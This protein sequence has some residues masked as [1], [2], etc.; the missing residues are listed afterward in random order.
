[1]EDTLLPLESESLDAKISLEPSGC[2][3]CISRLQQSTQQPSCGSP[4]A[5]FSLVLSDLYEFSDVATKAHHSSSSGT[6]ISQ[7]RA[8]RPDPTRTRA[9]ARDAHYI[10]LNQ[11]NRC[12]VRPAVRDVPGKTSKHGRSAPT[13]DLHYGNPP[14]AF[15]RRCR[16]GE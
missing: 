15:F 16:P 11:W 6:I 10:L 4:L 3:T 5:H 2:H 9:S 7:A 8:T 1:M 12:W 13:W 14:L